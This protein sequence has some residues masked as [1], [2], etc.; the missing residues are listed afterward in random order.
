MNAFFRNSKNSPAF[1]SVIV[2]RKVP[3]SL[4]IEHP[5]FESLSIHCAGTL[6]SILLPVL[7]SHSH[8]VQRWGTKPVS[9][10]YIYIYRE[11]EREMC[12]YIYIYVCVCIY[13]YIYM[14]LKRSCFHGDIIVNNVAVRQF[15]VCLSI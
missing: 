6:F 1:L 15:K 11:R 2:L 9:H 3:S 4:P 10:I 5:G 8:L 7:D 14:L 12:V 13:V